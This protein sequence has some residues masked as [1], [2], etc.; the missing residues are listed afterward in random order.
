MNGGMD[1]DGDGKVSPWER[2][3]WFSAVILGILFGKT[4]Y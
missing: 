4:L 1:L 2:C 3:V